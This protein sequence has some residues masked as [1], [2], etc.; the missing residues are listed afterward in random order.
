MS[1]FKSVNSSSAFFFFS[2]IYLLN[3][4]NYIK[5]KVIF[6]CFNRKKFVLELGKWC[7]FSWMSFS[8]FFLKKKQFSFGYFKVNKIVFYH[9]SFKKVIYHNTINFNVTGTYEIINRIS[10]CSI[11]F[12]FFVLYIKWERNELTYIMHM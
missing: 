11:F 10:R 3:K 2:Y 9:N 5:C 1:H 7:F 8:Y 12:F 4:C 6:F